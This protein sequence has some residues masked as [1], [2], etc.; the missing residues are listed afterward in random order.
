MRAQGSKRT[1]NT[2]VMNNRR[3]KMRKL[4]KAATVEKMAVY[5]S[6]S[7]ASLREICYH[8]GFSEGFNDVLAIVV[9]NVEHRDV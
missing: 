3:P 5:D 7:L 4:G 2:L 6:R 9:F 8:W 1:R